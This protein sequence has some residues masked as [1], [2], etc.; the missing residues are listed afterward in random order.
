MSDLTE[1]SNVAWVRDE[2]AGADFG[3]RRLTERAIR[4]VEACALEPSKSLPRAMP[5]RAQLDGAYRFLNNGAVHPAAVLM[6]HYEQTAQ[7]AA[8]HRVALAVHDT[9]EF[10]FSSRRESLG[11]LRSGDHG[12]LTHMS[13]AVTAD[14]LRR[15]LG[16]L[17]M[18]TWTRADKPRPKGRSKAAVA[19]DESRES[20]RWLK[21]I[22]AVEELVDGR[23]KLIHVIDREGDAFPLLSAMCQAEIQF[24]V[25]CA[26][27]RTAREEGGEVREKVSAIVARAHDEFTM[28]VPLSRRPVKDTPQRKS[29]APRDRRTAKLVAS[30][31]TLEIKKPPYIDDEPMWLEANV[32]RVREI[33][34]PDEVV[35]V[36]WVLF[37]NLPI[38]TSKN[39]AA[40]IDHYCA[41]WLI[42][43][44]FKA[45]KTGCEYEKMQLESYKALGNALALY[46]PIAWR[47]LLLRNLARTEPKASADTVLTKS[48]IEVL[49]AFSS[50]RLGP[51]V[52]VAE[53]FVAIAN[54][55]GYIKHKKPPGW[56]TLARGFEKLSLL[57]TG[58]SAARRKLEDKM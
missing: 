58:W 43:E 8:V 9:S 13:L 42:E 31:T 28:E 37:T 23:A 22:K 36:E 2:F 27:D 34:P 26:R 7:R 16:A 49:R 33:D 20:T 29:L 51:L 35:P 48:E 5:K 45:L 12:F 11:R 10:K 41:R 39:V 52:T 24:V 1:L 38:E 54:L 40:I 4:I 3:D 6:S 56:L 19:K 17:G 25:R 14:G 50:M 15:P 18:G 21:Q 53:A 47:M 55:G 30:A 32:V 44:F 46:V 57:E